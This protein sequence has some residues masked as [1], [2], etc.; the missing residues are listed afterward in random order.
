MVK[1]EKE[2]LAV[3]LDTDVGEE[4]V[5]MQQAFVE[6][7][8]EAVVDSVKREFRCEG[9]ST[10]DIFPLHIALLLSLMIPTNLSASYLEDFQQLKQLKFAE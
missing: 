3:E 10:H 4:V 8:V 5:Q 9:Q 6:G 2:Y 1:L 7:V